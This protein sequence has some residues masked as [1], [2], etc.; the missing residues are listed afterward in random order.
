M[1]R[2]RGELLFPLCQSSKEGEPLKNHKSFLGTDSY[3]RDEPARSR[4]GRCIPPDCG[5]SHDDHAGVHAGASAGTMSHDKPL[6][7]KSPNNHDGKRALRVRS[8]VAIAKSRTLAGSEDLTVCGDGASLGLKTR[9]MQQSHKW[10]RC[11]PLGAKVVILSL[12]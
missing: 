6:H 1:R 10:G 8:D 9:R 12:A 2:K 3:T 4:Q 11:D 7:D 5:L